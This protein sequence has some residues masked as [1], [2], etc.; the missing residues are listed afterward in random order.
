MLFRDRQVISLRGVDVGL[1]SFLDVGERRVFRVALRY[2]AGEARTLGNPE[3]GTG[4]LYGS[5]EAS[6]S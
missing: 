5:K 1:D 2:T 4:P 6:T 3:A